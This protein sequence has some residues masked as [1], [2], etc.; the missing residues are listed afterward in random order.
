MEEKMNK[1][2]AIKARMWAQIERDGP[3]TP[4]PSTARDLIGLVAEKYGISREEAKKLTE[5]L[6]A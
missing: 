3:K 2:D 6:G 4:P 5:Q 1:A